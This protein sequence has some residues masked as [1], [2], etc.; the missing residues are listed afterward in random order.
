MIFSLHLQHLLKL[1]TLSPGEEKKIKAHAHLYV[2]TDIG[3][4]SQRVGMLEGLTSKLKMTFVG[5]EGG[6][7]RLP[8]M[9]RMDANHGRSE[10]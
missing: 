5:R 6:R 10:D 8:Q 4:I 3:S 1:I 9:A 2:N 7:E